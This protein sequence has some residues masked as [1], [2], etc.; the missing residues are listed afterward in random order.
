M[1]TAESA[2]RLAA[3]GQSGTVGAKPRWLKEALD[4][5]VTKLLPGST[6]LEMEVPR[7]GDVPALD[8]SQQDLWLQQPRAQDTALD[9][10]AL[11]TAEVQ[12]SDASGDYYDDNVLKAILKFGRASRSKSARFELAPANGS[13]P[14]F[15]LAAAS[16]KEIAERLP[17]IPAPQACV[18]SGRLDEIGHGLRRFRL[19]IG[20]KVLQG[21]LDE[22]IVDVELLRPLWGRQVTVQGMVRFKSN[23]WPRVIQARRIDERADG[24]R[25]FEKMPQA[26][27]PGRGPI[28]QFKARDGPAGRA[29][30]TGRLWGQV[31]PMILWGAW[32]GDEPIEELLAA[33][34]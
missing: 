10:A 17:L 5:T 2:T 30:P 1:K 24:D 29:G 7:L 23:G 33:L 32:P 4:V 3:T 25:F 14:G 27:L 19:Q 31:D 15:S 12:D 28:D 16:C 11:A 8:L 22:G 18:V 6:I 13:R 26:E 9:L 20:D 21:R 34:D